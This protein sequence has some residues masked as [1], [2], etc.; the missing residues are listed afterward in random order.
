MVK[1]FYNLE[2]FDTEI[3]QIERSTF[4]L[5]QI[6]VCVCVHA[7]SDVHGE[8]GLSVLPCH[9]VA[10]TGFAKA[11]VWVTLRQFAPHRLIFLL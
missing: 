2:T 8:G 11:T 1:R 6:C 5:T 7:P 3:I 10:P 9:L 4:P